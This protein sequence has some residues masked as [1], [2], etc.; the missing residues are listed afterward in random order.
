MEMLR[1]E[2]DRLHE[3]ALKKKFHWLNYEN[4]FGSYKIIEKVDIISPS[5]KAL[6]K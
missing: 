6:L 4:V 5:L 3:T 1:R 2:W